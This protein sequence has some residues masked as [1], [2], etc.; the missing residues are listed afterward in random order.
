MIIGRFANDKYKDGFILGLSK[1]NVNRLVAGEPIAIRRETH[2][3]GVPEGMAIV[4]IYGKTEQEIYLSLKTEGVVSPDCVIYERHTTKN[5]HHQINRLP[6]RPALHELG[7]P[8]RKPRH[9]WHP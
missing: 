7:A 4:I 3:E 1:E 5:Y 9:P 8:R 2:G 6:Q